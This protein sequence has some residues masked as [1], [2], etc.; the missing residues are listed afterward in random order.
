M[1]DRCLLEAKLDQKRL[2]NLLPAEAA[3]KWAH[4]GVDMTKHGLRLACV[5]CCLPGSKQG[6][7]LGNAATRDHMDAY[8]HWL[9]LHAVAADV[10]LEG[11]VKS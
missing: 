2:S 5:L 10:G 4:L 11:V 7:G 8:R 3:S 9:R 6:E 1:L